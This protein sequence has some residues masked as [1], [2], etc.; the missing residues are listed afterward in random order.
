MAGAE[1]LL[2][3]RRHHLPPD[4]RV[5]FFEAGGSARAFSF[6]LATTIDSFNNSL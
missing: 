1:E 4:L 6:G 2:P 3:G 5:A